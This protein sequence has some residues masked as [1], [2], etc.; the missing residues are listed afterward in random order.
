MSGETTALLTRTADLLLANG[1]TTEGTRLAVERLGRAQGRPVRFTA[2]WGEYVLQ[3]PDETTFGE[4]AP[5]GVDIARVEATEAVVDG[6]CAGRLDAGEGLA[7]LEEVGR[8]DP[9]AIGRFAPMAAVGAAALSIV[10]GAADW[11]TVGLIA[12]S[13]A[14]GALLRRAASHASDN[15]FLQPFVASLLAGSLG[16][17][18]MRFHLPVADRLVV[19][20]PC[21]VLVP[22][23]HLLNGGIDLMR[24]RIPIGAGRVG[25]ALLIVLAICGGLL[26][27][28]A[29]TG[30]AFPQAGPPGEVPLGRDIL[31]AG[32]A[33]AA[34]GSFFNM[35]WRLMA[36]PILVGMAAHA[37]H[38]QLLEHGTSLQAGA[39]GA[40]LLVG[41][42]IAPLADRFRL[43]FGA[44]AFAA[45][46]SLIPGVLMFEAASAALAAVDLGAKADPA[47]LLPIVGNAAAAIL[48]V[49]AMTAGLILP[50]MAFDAL[51]AGRH[52]R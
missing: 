36:V 16:G 13:A 23:P 52:R 29:L 10:F 50:K 20:C 17:L 11:P 18:V 48:V 21:M 31:A 44:S 42:V 22:G 25:L 33:V 26:S 5:T 8:S 3:S 28:L 15:P 41:S 39:F 47:S 9:V 24:A 14:C 46:V 6:I 30:T 34:Y 1:Q 19:V 35:P 49:L 2:R 27:G 37:V 40:T 7:R 51:K 45:V 32:F 38:W 43:P 4:V 12:A